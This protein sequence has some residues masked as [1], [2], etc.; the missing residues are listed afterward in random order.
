MQTYC[1]PYAELKRRV[2][3]DTLSRPGEPQEE[4]DERIYQDRVARGVDVGYYFEGRRARELRAE[5]IA[6]A[7]APPPPPPSSGT[8]A[9]VEEPEDWLARHPLANYGSHP[10]D[11]QPSGGDHDGWGSPPSDWEPDDDEPP[12]QPTG[13]P[14]EQPTVVPAYAPTPRAMFFHR[15]S[16]TSQQRLDAHTAHMSP[17]EAAHHRSLAPAP[18]RGADGSVIMEAFDPEGEIPYYYAVGDPNRPNYGLFSPTGYGDRDTFYGWLEG[19]IG[20][21]TSPFRSRR[22]S[23]PQ[24][25][26][27]PPLRSQ[28]TGPDAAQRF[29]EEQARW[30]SAHADGAELHGTRREQNTL[31]DRLKDRVF[32][33]RRDRANP[34]GTPRAAACTL[35]ES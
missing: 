20:F 13:Q 14:A 10:G 33:Y 12:A 29:R 15:G 34:S 22:P 4:W 25:P 17:G 19:A 11:W 26:S 31:F 27:P 35:R 28:F 32:G 23:Q 5:R 1:L 18:V 8:A 2:D 24:P 21:L 7:G 9:A 16:F 6:A 3:E 30:F